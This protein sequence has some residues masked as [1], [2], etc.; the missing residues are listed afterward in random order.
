MSDGWI[1]LHRKLSDNPLWYSEPFTRGQAWVDL[2]LLANH[3]DGFFY[4]R[5]HKITV[6][7]GQ[8]G[9]SILKLATRWKWSR[10]KATKFLNDLEKEQ[11]VKQLQ[12]HSTTV[13]TII[14]YESYQKKE[15]QVEQQKSNRKTTEKQQEDT[16]KNDKNYKNDKKKELVLSDSQESDHPQR[17]LSKAEKLKREIEEMQSALG[18]AWA[19]NMEYYRNKY[20]GRDIPLAIASMREWIQANPTKAKKRID[21][22]LFVQNWLKREKPEFIAPRQKN[23]FSTPTTAELI[24]SEKNH[25]AELDK[26]QQYFRQLDEY[27]RQMDAG[28]ISQDEYHRLC[29]ILTDEYEGTA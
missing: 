25:K 20:P 11:Q 19:T 9:W 28:E 1:K 23:K 3:E 27:K 21:W 15:Q 10:S 2:L 29:E 26:D 4:L 18:A 16:N 7:R 13:I 14:N 22:N 12:S 24:E 8:V 6:L 17:V 5:D